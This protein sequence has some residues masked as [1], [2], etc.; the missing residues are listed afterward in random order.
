[1]THLSRVCMKKNTPEERL[2]EAKRAKKSAKVW[3]QQARNWDYTEMVKRYPHRPSRLAFLEELRQRNF[4]VANA[5][6]QADLES[7]EP[8]ISTAAVL[9]ASEPSGAAGCSSEAAG[10]S[11]EAA[12]GI[13]VAED[14]SSEGS[15]TDPSDRT[16]QK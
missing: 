6:N 10:V 9:T 4:F 7:E 2:E 3:T 8:S 15:T 5:P 12:G 11:S 14:S 1:M 13:L 16:W